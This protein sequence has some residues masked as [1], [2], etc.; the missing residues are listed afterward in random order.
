MVSWSTFLLV[1]FRYHTIEAPSAT[2]R[3]TVIAADLVAYLSSFTYVN[4]STFSG[5]S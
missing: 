4:D 2:P 3:R 1:E 5:R